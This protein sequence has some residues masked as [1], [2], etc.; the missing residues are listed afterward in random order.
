LSFE[1]ELDELF[2]ITH[3]KQGINPTP[4]LREILTPDLEAAAR[5]LNSRVQAAFA[6][7]KQPER[8]DAPEP[9]AA[10]APERNGDA[11]HKPSAVPASN[12]THTTP[13]VAIISPPEPKEDAYSVAV[14]RLRGGRFF[15]AR[16]V[17][18]KQQLVLNSDHAFYRL[19]YEP[20]KS[21]TRRHLELL[22]LAHSKAEESGGAAEGLVAT[23]ATALATRL[24]GDA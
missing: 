6:A 7:V 8:A 4:E 5:Q 19:V 21:E 1:P 10:P 24:E 17:K 3:S 16:L 20:S 22:L 12:G 23:W 11:R 2:A 13:R 14:I 15:E 18:G 9:D